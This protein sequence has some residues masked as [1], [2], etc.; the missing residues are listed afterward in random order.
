[1]HMHLSGWTIEQTIGMGLHLCSCFV[2]AIKEGLD[3][4]VHFHRLAQAFAYRP[5]L[6]VPEYHVLTYSIQASRL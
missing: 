1:M 4:A 3:E 2:H 5:F 6:Y